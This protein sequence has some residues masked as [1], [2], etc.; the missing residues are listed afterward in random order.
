MVQQHV[1]DPDR[2]EDVALLGALGRGQVGV[3]R[4]DERRVLQVGPVQVGEQEQPGEVQR[5]GEPEDLVGVDAQLAG[6]QVEHPLG[7]VL[8]HL[9]A[10]RG[11]EPAPGQ[12]LLQGRQQVLDVV[13][14]DL[15]VLVAGDPER[16][17][18]ADL[19]AGEE[20]VQ[21]RGDEVLERDEA[22][23]GRPV[24]VGVL[25]DVG[26]HEEAGQGLWDLD[27]GEVLRLGRRVVQH[28][29]EVERQARDVGERVSRVDG[30]RGE[31][32]ED[33]F[34]EEPVQGDLLLLGQLVPAH[35]RDALVGKRGPDLVP[36]DPGMQAHELL[37]HREQPVEQ[38]AR[39]QPCRGANGEAGRDAP[40]E[41]GDA[42]HE[43]LVEVVGEDRQELRPLQQRDAVVH[44]QLQHPLVELQPR[45]LPFEEAVGGQLLAGLRG[46]SGLCCSRRCAAPFRGAG[47]GQ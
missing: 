41:A 24:T 31:H 39:L 33:R 43:E 10:H 20:L 25:G 47:A 45:D 12:L 6:E 22:G 13:L 2:G 21:V 5:G 36:E 38:L 29:R 27:P 14:F 30:K 15:E 46:D 18:L 9:Q 8:G 16:A 37:G 28:H 34:T 3:G 1:L 40:L 17:V 19:H 32:G 35:Q 44:G 26:D 23:A 11:T 7:H 42:H 4:R